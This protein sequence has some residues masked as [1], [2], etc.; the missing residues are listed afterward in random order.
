[1]SSFVEDHPA[2]TLVG[3]VLGAIV[4]G[5][6]IWFLAFGIQWGTAPIRGKLQAREQIYSGNF[7]IQAYNSFFDKC[8]SVQ[9]LDQALNESY[10]ELATATGDD[11]S[12]IE[13]NIGAQ[14]NSRNDAVNQYN[15][16]SHKTWT[17]G[18]F[19]ARNLPYSLP[20]YQKGQVTS[21]GA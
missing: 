16:D 5:F 8:A 9:T 19:K 6:A 4:I 14:L 12:R 20:P 21:C 18:Q 17:V 10:S 15:A 2:L 11:K 7:T 13:T 1:V 3:S